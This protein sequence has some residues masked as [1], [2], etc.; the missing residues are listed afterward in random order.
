MTREYCR[1]A[2]IVRDDRTVEGPLTKVRN[3]YESITLFFINAIRQ[4][5]GCWFIDHGDHFNTSHFSG[6]L[7]TLALLFIEVGRHR[8]HRPACCPGI[9]G[10]LAVSYTHLR[11]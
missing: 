7:Y 6:M 4:P 10:E 8:D 1:L 2:A 9:I 3:H 5:S 11:A